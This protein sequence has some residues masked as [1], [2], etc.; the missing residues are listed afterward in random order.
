MVELS[1]VDLR[2]AAPAPA[3]SPSGAA[4]NQHIDRV[5]RVFVAHHFSGHMRTN[6][7][8]HFVARTHVN[9]S[10][11]AT[12]CCILHLSCHCRRVDMV[13][14]WWAVLLTPLDKVGGFDLRHE[15][16]HALLAA[17]DIILDFF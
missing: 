13:L 6:I 2:A 1:C 9:G 15:V 7:D 12:S 14:L 17:L 10:S 4:C 5:N 8:Q 3:V 16:V 11:T